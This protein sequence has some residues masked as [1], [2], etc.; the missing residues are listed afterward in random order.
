MKGRG[1]HKNRNLA[2]ME[3]DIQ[4]IATASVLQVFKMEGRGTYKN[5]NVTY[6]HAYTAGGK[7]S[8]DCDCKCTAGV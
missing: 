1:T 3:D 8:R 4:E 5:R 6:T 7:Y 2:Y